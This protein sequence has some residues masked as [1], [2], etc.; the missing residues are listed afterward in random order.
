MFFTTT[1]ST[2]LSSASVTAE[3]VLKICGRVVGAGLDGAGTTK[4]L[5]WVRK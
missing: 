3:E 1:D 4:A 2:V 5:I